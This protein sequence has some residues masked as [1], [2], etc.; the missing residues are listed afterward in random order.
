VYRIDYQIAHHHIAEASETPHQAKQ[1]LM[2]QQQH[3]GEIA[4]VRLALHSLPYVTSYELPFRLLL[5]RAPQAIEKL[6]DELTIHCRR[7]EINGNKRGVLYSLKRDVVAPEAFRYSRRFRVFRSGAEGGTES[8]Y[9]HIAGQVSSPRERLRLALT[10]GLLV[11]ALDALLF[12][13]V[14]RIASDIAALR[15]GGLN[16]DLLHVEAFDSQTMQLREIPAYRMI[17]DN[18][19]A[20]SVSLAA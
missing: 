19:I 7:V 12:F 20:A 9:T 4:R 1:W 10:S 13:G 6:R 18:A 8:S 15:K 3:A 2:V 17:T 16:I 5:I 14:Q 11:T